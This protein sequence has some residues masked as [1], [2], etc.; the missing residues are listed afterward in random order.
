MNQFSFSIYNSDR[1]SLVKL[2]HSLLDLDIQY[3]CMDQLDMQY[4]WICSTPGYAVH[5]DMQYTWVCTVSQMDC[6][7]FIW[8]YLV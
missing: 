5:L 7:R 8:T 6:L 1:V 3:T 2:V 4:T